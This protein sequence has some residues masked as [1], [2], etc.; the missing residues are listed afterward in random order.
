MPLVTL[1]KMRR[2]AGTNTTALLQKASAQLSDSKGVSKASATA[3]A[4]DD[5]GLADY[6]QTLN[7]KP[8]KNDMQWDKFGDLSDISADETNSDK[9]PQKRTEP[10]TV[11]SSKFIKKKTESQ[12]VPAGQKPTQT[13]SKMHTAGDTVIQSSLRNIHA[14]SSALGKAQSFAAKYKAS[15]GA[16]GKITTLSSDSDMELNLSPD[17]E[18]LANIQVVKHTTRTG[19][20]AVDS[21]SNMTQPS[22][23]SKSA[24]KSTG[25]IK[26]SSLQSVNKQTTDGKT[27]ASSLT[28]ST[29][30]QSSL[31]HSTVI[32]T[33][34][35]D[36]D[37][38]SSST[39]IGKGGSK[40][41][42]Q[43]T[44]S[45]AEIS[46]LQDSKLATAEK[47]LR[48]SVGK[49]QSTAKEHTVPVSASAGK[50]GHTVVSAV[51]SDDESLAEFIGQLGSD[52]QPHVSS[53]ADQKQHTSSSHSLIVRSDI[54]TSSHTD[55]SV[56][57]AESDNFHLNV[58]GV[59]ALDNYVDNKSAAAA[60]NDVSLAHL[61]VHTIDELLDSGGVDT[62]LRLQYESDYESDVH[63]SSPTAAA[64][65]APAL[66]SIL[67]IT[68]RSLTPKSTRSRVRLMDGVT[69]VRSRSLSSI[70]TARSR[71]ASSVSTARSPV[72]DE[73]ILTGRSAASVQTVAS[74][75]DSQSAAGSELMS[76]AS[77]S[78]VTARPISRSE[79]DCQ[80]RRCMSRRRSSEP[81]SVSIGQRSQ[82]QGSRRLSETATMIYSED[83]TSART[84][85]DYSELIS[86]ISDEMERQ[87]RRKKHSSPTH[88]SHRSKSKSIQTGLDVGLQYW[89]PHGS[90]EAVTSSQFGLAFVDPASV[91]ATVVS[92][93]TLEAVTSYS[94][95]M[96]AM[97]DFL[98]QQ[99]EL[100]RQFVAG[101]RR[102]HRD[103][104]LS[105]HSTGESY[106]YTTL[107]NT[108]DFIR[109]HRHPVTTFDDALRDVKQQMHLV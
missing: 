89:W 102:L 3:A 2:F 18:V 81:T 80:P 46:D 54:S 35:D 42:K 29:H 68:P 76:T 33:I 51:D 28:H 21:G 71:S 44:Q 4:V 58:C 100:S 106:H 73:E 49:N 72:P 39:G 109:K 75:S 67:S 12:P 85:V 64:V 25:N 1:V 66:R 31:F 13:P 79:T 8:A 32:H 41:I 78:E 57:E 88:T 34:S 90:A 52:K 55:D 7:K 96:L 19:H 99:L 26:S 97:N 23:Q 91:A 95:S 105:L 27:S 5:D 45:L 74:D 14:H 86:S 104:V 107:S 24:S 94:P 11:S 84:S 60:D 53:S 50:L 63:S 9:M 93:D 6:L 10:M 98:R 56:S 108:K 15:G 83:F 92:A 37:S 30:P 36:E 38:R 43:H 69:E 17:E 82:R 48:K 101:Q 62:D 59:D 61:G 22:V 65:A 87:Q 47:P 16:A 70:S 20:I 40:F 77:T 103:L